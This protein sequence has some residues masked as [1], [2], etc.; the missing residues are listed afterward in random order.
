MLHSFTLWWTN[1]Y[2]PDHRLKMSVAKGRLI[3]AIW[4]G[5]EQMICA[6]GAVKRAIEG[7]LA[8]YDTTR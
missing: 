3:A 7:V 8:A 6:D 5:A 1:R 2:T 4:K